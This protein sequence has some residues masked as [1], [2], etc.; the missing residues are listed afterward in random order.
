MSEQEDI[1]VA[2]RDSLNLPGPMNSWTFRQMLA[3]LEKAARDNGGY[4]DDFHLSVRNFSRKH[5]GLKGQRFKD[6]KAWIRMKKVMSFSEV[7]FV[8]NALQKY[9]AKKTPEPTRSDL[10]DSEMVVGLIQYTI[11]QIMALAQLVKK[12][13][14]RP[15]QVAKEDSDRVA[16]HIK[17]ICDA[18]GIPVKID[19]SHQGRPLSREEFNSIS[20]GDEVI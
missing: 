9:L 8:L 7:K 13:G 12:A 5:L 2:A 18:Y 10:H 17:S 11:T 1:Y 16:V 4:P 3:A 14:V 6:V 19:I 20:K 15:E